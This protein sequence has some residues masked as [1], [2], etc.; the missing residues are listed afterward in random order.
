MSKTIRLKPWFFASSALICFSAGAMA[1]S[2]A[3]SVSME[4]IGPD[5][6][7]SPN[8]GGFYTDPYTAIIGAAGQTKPVISGV[9]TQ[10]IC[11][12]FQTDVSVDTPPWQA[13]LTTLDSIL[14]ETSTS[15][16]LKFDDGDSVAQQQFDYEVAA[17]LAIQITDTNQSTV[18]G[19]LAAGE[20][21]YALWAVFDPASDPTGPLADPDL[22]SSEL[23]VIKTDLA[24]AETA[25]TDGWAP[26]GYTVDIYT[27][28]PIGASQEYITVSVSAPEASTPILMAVDLLGLL[29]LV[30]F[31]RRRA[32]RKA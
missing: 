31:L 11:D 28:S 26:T 30:G 4:L 3:P 25:V 24:A 5:S 21:S 14:S 13:T 32:L 29:T 23:S 15:Q 7:N 27:P 6:I 17:Y 19:Q 16:V 22:S 8:L 10:V 2:P 9:V 12:D 20:L 18:G 1:T